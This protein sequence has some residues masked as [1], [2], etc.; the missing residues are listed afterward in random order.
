MGNS[1]SVNDIEI[2]K[3][4]NQR[5]IRINE[6]NESTTWTSMLIMGS[7]LKHDLKR[8]VFEAKAV[9]HVFKFHHTED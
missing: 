6:T 5:N 2:P 1:K 8:R 4:V 3:Y 7:G 9:P